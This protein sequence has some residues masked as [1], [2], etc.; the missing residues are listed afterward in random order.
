MLV[1]K[2]SRDQG[3]ENHQGSG[4]F[5]CTQYINYKIRDPG[6][7]FI[8]QEPGIWTAKISGIWDMI[9]SATH[10]SSIIQM[11]VSYNFQLHS[12]PTCSRH[13][14]LFIGHYVPVLSSCSVSS[15]AY[16]AQSGM[17]YGLKDTTTVQDYNDA[18]DACSAE[19]G[20][21]PVVNSQ[22]MLDTLTAATTD[23]FSG[24]TE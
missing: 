24:I 9:S 12:K 15:P 5:K 21:L 22:S 2:K 11:S 23:I 4:N 18:K 13:L 8:N 3:C 10:Y 16:D 7:Q 20:A 14:L 6:I 19:N 17:C 1:L